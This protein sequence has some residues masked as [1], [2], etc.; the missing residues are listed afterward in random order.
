MKGRR[1]EKGRGGGGMENKIEEKL[2][3]Y[4]FGNVKKEI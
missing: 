2:I 3:I 4:S 1:E